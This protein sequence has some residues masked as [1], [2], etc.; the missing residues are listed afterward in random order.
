MADPVNTEK[1]PSAEDLEGI[2]QASQDYIEGWYFADAKRMQRCLHPDLV[3]RTLIHDETEDTWRLRQPTTMARMVEHTRE[4][5]GS[6]IPEPER[7]YEI[8]ILDV[9]RHIATVKI[10]SRHMVD[11]LHVVKL[12]GRWQIANILWEVREGEINDT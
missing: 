6:W 1:L 5:G 9:F 2:T 11:Y 3:K 4:G 8:T 12:G 7:T 10:Q